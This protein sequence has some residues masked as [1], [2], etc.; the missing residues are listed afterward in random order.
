MHRKFYRIR[1][2]EA[3]VALIAA[4][5]ACAINMILAAVW[6]PFGFQ[7]ER[8]DDSARRA[9]ALVPCNRIDTYE[10]LSVSGVSPVIVSI[11]QD[12]I[13]DQRRVENLLGIRCVKNP[14]PTIRSQTEEDSP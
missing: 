1:P 6:D 3:R 8:A 5:V 7:E 4:L 10:R 9:T 14:P 12:A 13:E 2:R 11:L